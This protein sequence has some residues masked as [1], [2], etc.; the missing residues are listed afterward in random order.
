MSFFSDLGKAISNAIGYNT[1]AFAAG[2]LVFPAD[3]NTEYSIVLRFYAYSRQNFMSIGTLSPLDRIRLPIPTNLT[4]GYSVNYSNE[5]LSSAI[6][7]ATGALTGLSGA[8]GGGD[9]AGVASRLGNAV[10]AVTAAGTVAAV[11]ALS[12][13]GGSA[14]Q[15][16]LGVA[17]N[18]FTTVMFKSPEYKGYQFSWRLFPRT[19]QEAETVT[20]IINTIRFHALPDASPTMGGAILTYPSLIKAQIIAKGQELYPFKYGVI[21]SCSF[22][23][24]PDGAPS[25]H[26]DGKPSAV[27]IQ[28]QIQEIEYFLKSSMGSS[29]S[30]L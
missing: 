18:P 16:F 22:N 20:K 4:D 12:S 8:I 30:Y 27:D 1:K 9:V 15:A 25:F 28:I 11:G 21:K 10:S 6:G 23:Y 29:T 14:A 7:G 2:P 5:D 26:K 24:A 19:P 13:A 3:L 17:P